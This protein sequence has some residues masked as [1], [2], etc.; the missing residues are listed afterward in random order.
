MK[1]KEH[2][3]TCRCIANIEELETDTSFKPKTDIE[4]G[5]IKMYDSVLQR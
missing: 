5:L 1:L 2:R 3:V 4:D